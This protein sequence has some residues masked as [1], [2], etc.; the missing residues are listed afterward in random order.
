MILHVRAFV[1]WT[2]ISTLVKTILS[3]PFDTLLVETFKIWT[4]RVMGDTVVQIPTCD[5]MTTVPTDICG[6]QLKGQ[7]SAIQPI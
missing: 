7:L 1:G 3:C 2:N 4:Y 6:L 5:S